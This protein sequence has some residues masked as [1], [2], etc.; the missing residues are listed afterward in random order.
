MSNRSQYVKF[1]NVR[2]DI[3]ITNTGAPQGCVLSPLL[4]SLYTN[5]CVSCNNNCTVVKYADDTV[6]LGKILNDDMND[7]IQQVNEFVDWCD[8][9]FLNL[10]VTKTKEML[11]DFRKKQNSVPPLII[12]SESVEKVH[13][14]K[15]LGIVIDDK[16]SG[17]ANT[18]A[19]YSKC[20]QRVHHLRILKNICVDRTILSLFYKSIIE[21]VLCFSLIIFYGSLTGKNKSKLEKIVRN[22]KRLG[23]EVSSLNGLY[24]KYMKKFVDKIMVDDSHPL[25]SNFIFLRSGRRLAMPLIRTTRF[26]NSFIPKGIKLFNYVQSKS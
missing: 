17:N 11:F 5:D 12:K 23:A 9:N 25:Y 26:K 3:I 1:K 13:E 7:Y 8:I 10:N 4:F 15:Y 21:S 18:D 20:R 24:D 6:I 16:L 2:S 14:Y 22:A 19:V